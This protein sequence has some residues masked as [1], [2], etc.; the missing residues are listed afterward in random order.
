MSNELNAKIK[1]LIKSEK[2]MFNLE[3][4]KKS[5]QSV[6]IAM[7]IVAVLAVLITLNMTVFF[8]LE[9]HYTNL[10]SAAMLCGLNLVIAILFF[11]IASKQTTGPEAHSIEEIR[12]FA[13]SQVSSD[14]D[15]VKQ[16]VSEFKSS[17]KS[18]KKGVES[19][20]TGDA[21]GI[22]KIIPIIST[23][24]ELNK[25]RAAKKDEM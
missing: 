16:S 17:V 5:R 4:R 13:W 11:V 12:S 8:F 6:W 14:I 23:L 18:V 25:K 1:L 22:K 9:I 21:F 7:A 19:F 24:I 2:A 10:E 15:E 3:M 20:T